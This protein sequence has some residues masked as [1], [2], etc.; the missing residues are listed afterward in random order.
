[1]CVCVF[2]WVRHRENKRVIHLILDIQRTFLFMEEF[3]GLYVAMSCCVVDSVGSSLR[4]QGRRKFQDLSL[5]FA[6]KSRSL[7]LR[8]RPGV[9]NT[10]YQTV[11]SIFPILAALCIGILS[12]LELC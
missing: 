7:G 11:H 2:V 9:I 4:V 6:L 3:Q 1:M 10:A 8:L 5:T 12:D